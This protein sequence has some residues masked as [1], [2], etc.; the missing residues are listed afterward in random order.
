LRIRHRINRTA[1]ILSLCSLP[2]EKDVSAMHPSST[3]EASLRLQTLREK[4][5]FIRWFGV[6]DDEVID[7]CR[8]IFE[9]T[10]DEL[11]AQVEQL[12]LTTLETALH[13]CVT[14]LN[15]LNRRNQFINTEERECLCGEI[16]EIAFTVG[17]P[18]AAGIADRWRDW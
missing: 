17:Y 11:S 5:R 16:D 15:E 7:C 6:V 13:D 14:R 9:Y 1:E 8:N 18:A 10:I 4:R 2:L 3:D 12:S